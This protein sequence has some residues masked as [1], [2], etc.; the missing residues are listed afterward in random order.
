MTTLRM[1]FVLALFGAALVSSGV[2]AAAENEVLSR[3]DDPRLDQRVTISADGLRV[4]D[5]LQSLSQLTGV[6]MA[7]G[8]DASDWMVYDRRVIL[9]VSDMT[10]RLLMGELT[11]VLS[12][13]WTRSGET[14]KWTYFLL[15]DEAAE[16]EELTLRTAAEDGR[17]R[18]D[19][20]KRESALSDLVNL[21]SLSAADIDRLRETDPWRYVLASGSLAGDVARFLKSHSE[22]REA[23]LSGAGSSTPVAAMSPDLQATVKRIAESY[24]SLMKS[25]G[26]SGDYSELL[27]KF[28]KLQITIN[29]RSLESPDVFT[30][31]M[32]GSINIGYGIGPD[33]LEVPILDPTSSVARAFGSAVLKLRSGAKKEDVAKELQSSLQV[34]AADLNK[35]R[36]GH[37]RDITSDPDLK[38]PV[39]LFD[40]PTT[41]PLTT[42]LKKLAESSGMNVVSDYFRVSPSNMHSG[43]RTLGEQLELIRVTYGSNWEKLGRT[44]RLRDSE[45]FK[46]RTWEVPSVWMDHWAARG[47]QTDGLELAE[48][49]QIG[50]LRDEQ[51]DH[52]I[53]TDPV[54][55]RLGAGEAAR[56][57]QILR[58]YQSLDDTQRTQMVSQN[59]PVSSL[60]PDQW[61]RLRD[62][63]ATKGA[64]YAA[65]ERGGQWMKLSSS[66]SDVVEHTFSYH[67]EGN[68]APVT[69]KLTT[70]IVFKT[71]DEVALPQNPEVINVTPQ[72]K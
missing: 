69:F 2:S 55:V 49:A 23:F 27:G 16:T 50:R 63:L 42:T 17:H 26:A 68:D 12:F 30:Q 52:T 3:N 21:T 58:F 22:S 44:L 57:R 34:A 11:N 61:S 13:H 40:S 65:V 31:S 71:G 67:P 24:N 7:A 51:L 32:L 36:T 47:K 35:A 59:L 6:S 33:S 37:S 14:G 19:R 15:K 25:I 20:Q 53:M 28:D 56:N 62:A 48:L 29:R 18:M 41:A 45:W 5:V 1:I 70:G 9:H 10:L 39:E 64:A 38:K 60:S 8:R 66:G 54:L 4:A 72:P 46:K 43:Q